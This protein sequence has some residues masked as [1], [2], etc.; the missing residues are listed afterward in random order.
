MALCIQNIIIV[1][2]YIYT[3]VPTIFYQIRHIDRATAL[4]LYDAI[5]IPVTIIDGWNHEIK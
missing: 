5:I 4:C 3:S 1:L 2:H